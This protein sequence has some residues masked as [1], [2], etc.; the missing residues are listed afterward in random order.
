MDLLY[1]KYQQFS[2]ETHI[3]TKTID[4]VRN[5]LEARLKKAYAGGVWVLSQWTA[6]IAIVMVLYCWLGASL[7]PA[8]MEEDQSAAKN[9]SLIRYSIKGTLIYCLG[10]VIVMAIH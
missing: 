5:Y 8:L 10:W 7:F 2:G 6:N 3:E 9:Q 4:K 1:D